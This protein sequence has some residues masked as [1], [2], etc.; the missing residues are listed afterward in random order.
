M[1]YDEH[2]LPVFQET[3][4]EKPHEEQ[5]D[6]IMVLHEKNRMTKAALIKIEDNPNRYDP[7]KALAIIYKWTGKGYR[8]GV[9]EA[10]EIEISQNT[11][12]GII[13][14]NVMD[15]VMVPFTAFG[16]FIIGVIRSTPTAIQE[17]HRVFFDTNEVLLGILEFQYDDQDRMIEI[18]YFSPTRNKVLLS[19]TTFEYSHDS[20]VPIQSFNKSYAED[21]E[22]IIQVN[23]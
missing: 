16:G 11:I 6:Y 14:D 10:K 12:G 19:K 3:L 23:E 7:S 9:D 15:F 20:L 22:R 2:G 5:A 8:I 1:T 4:K 21:I 18:K 17:F 13:A